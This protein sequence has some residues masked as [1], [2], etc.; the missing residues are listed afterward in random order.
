M[1]FGVAQMRSVSIA[2]HLHAPA[3]IAAAVK[4]HVPTLVLLRNPEDAVLSRVISHPPITIHQALREYVHFFTH[5]LPYV[6]N[7]VVAGFQDVTTNFGT[8]IGAIN[9]AFGTH[10]IEFHHT[11]ENNSRCLKLIAA[12][13]ASR[14]IPEITFARPSA[15]RNTLKEELR[16]AYLSR[17]NSDLRVR[18]ENL[19]AVLSPLTCNTT[20]LLSRSR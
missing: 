7:V 15:Q 1:A 13:Q 20:V 17:A 6:S 3:Q 8:V 18:A 11:L 19:Y 9:N 4:R 2:H 12:R 14:G 5:I 16:A 10:F